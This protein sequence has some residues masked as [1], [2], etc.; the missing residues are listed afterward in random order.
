MQ[1]VTRP[2]A[3][4]ES[5]TGSNASEPDRDDHIMRDSSPSSS[6]TA[7]PRPAGQPALPVDLP[8]EAGRP[9]SFN[10]HPP[11]S[12]RSISEYNYQQLTIPTVEIPRPGN[13]V[14]Q[15]Y[16]P[17]PFGVFPFPPSF[18]PNNRV[19]SEGSWFSDQQGYVYGYDE[20]GQPLP[21]ALPNIGLSWAP[22]VPPAPAISPQFLPRAAEQGED[23][24]HCVCP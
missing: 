18:V 20:M 15:G 19:P 3:D 5:V 6:R 11:P 21:Q 7:T 17:A 24:L 10:I 8:S 1:D 4:T 9:P 23:P 22:V 14:Q 2:S 12:D 13:S 16:F